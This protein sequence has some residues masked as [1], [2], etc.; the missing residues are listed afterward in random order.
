MKKI[1]ITLLVLGVIGG[2]YGLYLFNK[3]SEDV[4]NKKVEVTI[5]ATELL[6]SFK[7]DETVANSTYLNKV[8]LVSGVV[9]SVSIEGTIQ[10]ILI[11]SND[12]MST[13][14]CEMS[15]PAESVNTGDKV[16]V[17]GQCA[18]YLIDVVLTKCVIEN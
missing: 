7:D 4:S 12:L 5:T 3:P 10:N 13:V 15:E 11:E 16:M 8:I 6:K 1:I 9:K 18:G 2:A 17:K 14:S